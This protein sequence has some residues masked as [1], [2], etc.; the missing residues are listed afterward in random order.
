MS[1]LHRLSIATLFTVLAAAGGCDEAEPSADA[2]PV[3][4]GREVRLIEVVTNVPGPDGA[5]ARFRFLAPGL[6]EAD[7]PASADD[8]QALCDTYALARIDG[9][10]PEP[11]QI[12]ISLAGEDVPFGEAAPDVV[13]FFEAFEVTDGTCI[14]AAF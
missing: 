1:V 3:P 6:T 4:S 14:L 10:V 11:Q 7:I 9:M 8:M 5:T 12:I 2:I 13:Q